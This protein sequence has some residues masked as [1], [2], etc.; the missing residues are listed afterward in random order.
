MMDMDTIFKPVTTQCMAECMGRNSYFPIDFAG[1]YQNS[2]VT[3]AQPVIPL[4][5]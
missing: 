4:F 2:A 3:T 5:V 1:H